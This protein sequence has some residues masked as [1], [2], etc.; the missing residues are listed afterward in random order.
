[1][2]DGWV[3]VKVTRAMYG[4]PQAGSLGQNQLEQRLNKE[5][6]FQ[7]QTVPGFWEH[8][9]KSIQFVWVVDDFGIKY[10]NKD[11]LDHLT[12]T[13]EKYYDVAVDLDGKEFVKIE[14]DWDYENKSVHWSMAPYLQKALRQFDNI[15]PT[16]RHDSHYPHIELKYGA[17]Q[18]AEYDMSA[19]V[20][21]DEQKLLQQVTG[22]FN[23]Y[24]SGV[25]GTLLMPISALSAQQAK[26][27]QARM[28]CV[29]Q[30]LDYA[31]T[32]EPAVTTYRASDMVLA[33]HSNAG[34]LNERGGASFFLSK[35][36]ANPSNNGAIYNEASIIKSVMSSAA[37]AEIGALYINA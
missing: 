7:S 3:Y 16:H 22:K 35:N 34:Y 1:M 5:G 23:W 11:D 37:E 25:D 27:T 6:Y 13:L 28:K 10:I 24:A 17:K 29:K 8:T 30:F 31:A 26:P 12:R 14:L 32:Q 9:T 21:K 33:I 2:S 18:Y 15:V 4:I 19:P 20:G 36:I